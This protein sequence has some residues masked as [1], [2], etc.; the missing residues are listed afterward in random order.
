MSNLSPIKDQSL[1][2]LPGIEHAFFTRP[3]G[4]SKGI[5][6]G[7][8]AGL[9]S[10]DIRS[11]V[12]EN[13][14]RMTEALGVSEDRLASPFQAPERLPSRALVPNRTRELGARRVV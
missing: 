5:Y 2:E 9:G 4:V 7:L 1:S 11:D 8:N 12:E 14:R 3:G 13:R 6:A 10:N